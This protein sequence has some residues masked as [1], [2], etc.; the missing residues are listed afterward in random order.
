M[1]QTGA[2]TQLVAVGAQDSNF[3]SNAPKDSIF[4]EPPAVIN[5]FAKQSHVLIPPGKIGWGSKF[6]MKIEKKGDLLHN[7][8]LQFTLPEINRD[9]LFNKE[10]ITD[11]SGHDTLAWN[12]MIEFYLVKKVRLYIGG[13]LIDE[14][15]GFNMLKEQSMTWTQQFFGDTINNDVGMN[16]RPINIKETTKMLRLEFWFTNKLDKALPLIALQHHEV[17]LEVELN[18]FDKAYLTFYEKADTIG[19]LQCPNPWADFIH[20]DKTSHPYRELKNVKIIGSYIYLDKDERKRIAQ[21]EHKILIKQHQNRECFLGPGEN[22]TTR[23]IELD[24]NHPV[25]E[26][27]FYFNNTEANKWEPNNFYANAGVQSIDVSNNLALTEKS[28]PNN[29]KGPLNT[30]TD[31]LLS[32]ITTNTTAITTGTHTNIATTTNNQ[33]SGCILTIVASGTTEVTGVTVTTAGQ[34]YKKG[35][36]LVVPSANIPGSGTNLIFTLKKDDVVVKKPVYQKP[37]YYEMIGRQRILGEARIII[38]GSPFIDWQDSRFFNELQLKNK[39]ISPITF[40][41]T[42][43]YVFAKSNDNYHYPTGSLNFSR[44]DNAKLQI[45]TNKKSYDWIKKFTNKS[46]MWKYNDEYIK[47]FIEATN[48]NYLIIKNGMAALAYSS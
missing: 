42:S 20:R 10:S 41:T 23:N 18:D 25:S 46:D 30:N 19:R 48:W 44:I 33:G 31:A 34:G 3:L 28:L 1:S 39:N 45:R 2:L 11:N 24:F 47:I 6:K 22:H 16:T 29:N 40:N 9:N 37:D 27:M 8:Y 5:N 26:L 21:S 13:E 7:L 17:E 4:I 32:S 38:N 15:T 14:R 43:H 35:D 36:L 12:R